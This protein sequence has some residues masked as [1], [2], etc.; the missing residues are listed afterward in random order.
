MKTYQ[1]MHL[2]YIL[3]NLKAALENA[4]DSM[5]EFTESG[6]T[7]EVKKFE[8]ARRMI[9]QCMKQVKSLES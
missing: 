1:E 4:E 3:G 2:D 6:N 7:E 8:S 9:L 5:M